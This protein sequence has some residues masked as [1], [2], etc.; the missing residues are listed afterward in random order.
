MTIY[1]E[2]LSTERS[3]HPK[4]KWGAMIAS[5]RGEFVEQDDNRR[6]VAPDGKSLDI[7]APAIIL[8]EVRAVSLGRVEGRRVVSGPGHCEEQVVVNK[9]QGISVALRIER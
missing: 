7:H 5:G 1:E 3:A 9:K 6:R 4:G 8:G 2:R